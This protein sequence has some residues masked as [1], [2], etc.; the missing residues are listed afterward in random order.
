[1]INILTLAIVG[2]ICIAT[3]LARKQIAAIFTEDSEVFEITSAVIPVV[4]GYFIFD[5]MQ[6]YL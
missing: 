5:G 3:G 4:A 2:T 1:M 6:G